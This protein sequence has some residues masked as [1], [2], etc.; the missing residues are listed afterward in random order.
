MKM[1]KKVEVWKDRKGGLHED[2]R[3]YVIAEV[4]L[5]KKSQ[6]EVLEYYIQ[7]YGDLALTHIIKTIINGIK[8]LKTL[9]AICEEEK[10]IDDLLDEY[11]QYK[12]TPDN[13]AG[14]SIEQENWNTSPGEWLG[15]SAQDLGIPNT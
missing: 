13:S 8:T 14:N 12:K 2:R 7:K 3:S 1:N 15:I 6:H 4:E 10:Q 9:D 11:R 5:Y